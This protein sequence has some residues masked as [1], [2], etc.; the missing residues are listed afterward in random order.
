MTDNPRW[1]AMA[2]DGN[3]NAHD[4]CLKVIQNMPIPLIFNG[5]Q[6]LPETG[7]GCLRQNASVC[8][9]PP[10]SRRLPAIID[11]NGLRQI[12]PFL[13]PLR[14]PFLQCLSRKVIDEKPFPY[15]SLTDSSRLFSTDV[16]CEDSSRRDVFLFK[17]SNEA[18]MHRRLCWA[19][20]SYRPDQS[21][22]VVWSKALY[23]IDVRSVS[24]VMPLYWEEEQPRYSSPPIPSPTPPPSS[25]LVRGRKQLSQLS[26]SDQ[27]LQSPD[28]C[29][30]D[31]LANRI[32]SPQGWL[33]GNDYCEGLNQEALASRTLEA[34]HYCIS[35]QDTL[36]NNQSF[37][38][39]LTTRGGTPAIKILDQHRSY[40]EEKEKCCDSESSSVFTQKHTC[41]AGAFVNNRSSLLSL[42]ARAYISLPS[43]VWGEKQEDSY[44]RRAKG[45]VFVYVCFHLYFERGVITD[46]VVR[47]WSL[48]SS[49][50]DRL[51]KST[52]HMINGYND[53]GKIF[54]PVKVK[55]GSALTRSS[56]EQYSSITFTSDTKLSLL[57]PSASKLWHHG[58]LGEEV[59]HPRQTDSWGKLDTSIK[60]G[61]PH[62]H[63]FQPFT[64]MHL[65]DLPKSPAAPFIHLPCSR[66]ANPDVSLMGWI[67]AQERVHSVRD[68]GNLCQI[69]TDDHGA[70]CQRRAPFKMDKAHKIKTYDIYAIDSHSTSWTLNLSHGVLEGSDTDGSNL[71]DFSGLGQEG[72][73]LELTFLTGSQTKV[74]KLGIAHSHSK[75]RD[76]PGQRRSSAP[77][78]PLFF[79]SFPPSGIINL[80]A[81]L[82]KSQMPSATMASRSM[83]PT[84]M[85]SEQK[86]Q[87]SPLCECCRVTPLH[88]WL[89]P[90]LCLT[91][92]GSADSDYSSGILDRS[93]KL[94]PPRGYLLWESAN[95]GIF[96]GRLLTNPAQGDS[97]SM[98]SPL[99]KNSVHNH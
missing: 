36:R 2:Q 99:P 61:P 15:F 72:Y 79:P 87:T 91:S 20:C 7:M 94:K 84:T 28:A 63:L 17:P 35:C 45:Y 13:L 3:I 70:A 66:R 14:P 10:P 57:P 65:E 52:G 8:C 4:Q 54:N 98:G 40:P 97:S 75:A 18:S 50:A 73:T 24:D 5:E 22:M 41:H 85:T 81:I 34:P 93:I 83:L 39:P 27:T 19:D 59:T 21:L 96:V 38:D 74:K 67:T 42:L 48:T 12:N 90:G 92:L 46:H 11:A 77:S 58:M 71:V 37:Q 32:G 80:S 60:K 26:T 1:A 51:S 76:L 55:Q 89:T 9:F 47:L 53:E 69:K 82:A 16:P 78:L 33:S 43:L 95:P 62:H 49:K 44:H 31:S 88:P 86:G 68:S 23:A 29:H 6:G 25:P 64:K 30:Q 56:Q